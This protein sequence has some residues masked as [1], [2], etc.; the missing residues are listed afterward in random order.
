MHSY[1]FPTQDDWVIDV[2]PSYSRSLEYVDVTI[3]DSYA[4][5]KEL[6][7]LYGLSSKSIEAVMLP[8][9]REVCPKR[10]DIVKKKFSLRTDLRAKSNRKL[11]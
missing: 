8:I 10:D 5:K 9:S 2:F 11:P 4:F 3:T 7:N 1:A 6:M